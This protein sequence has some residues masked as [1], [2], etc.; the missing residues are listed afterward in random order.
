MIYV[1]HG[2]V[3]DLDSLLFVHRNMVDEAS[4]T[5]WLRTRNA[6]FVSLSEALQGRGDALTIDDGT[7]AA[8]QAAKIA[9]SGGH[10]VTLFVN[11]YHCES[12]APYFF[13]LLNT[14]L[15]ECRLSSVQWRDRVYMLDSRRGKKKFRA[16]VKH[17]LRSLPSEA[18]RS[19]LVKDCLD[20]LEMRNIEPPQHLRSLGTADVQELAGL[21]VS[22]ENHAWTHGE[23][24][25]L[26]PRQV[27]EEID[28]ARQWLKRNLSIDSE[29]FAVPFG[30]TLPPNSGHANWKIWFLLTDDL[31]TGKLSKRLYNRMPL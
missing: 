29:H 12:Q 22:I 14:A 26:D 8:A 5:D 30:A 28:A 17:E 15:D 11:P 18:L 9:V 3:R 27:G 24:A 1:T 10:Q 21:G 23:F 16:G 13:A 19:A 6:P 20:A 4:Y 25:A 7:M 2:S 31:P